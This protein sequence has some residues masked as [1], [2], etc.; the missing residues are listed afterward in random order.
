M[1]IGLVRD[2]PGKTTP[3]PRPLRAVAVAAMLLTTGV[4]VP[5][6]PSAACTLD[7][8]TLKSLTVDVRS[9]K[10]SYTVGEVAE[11]ALSVTRPGRED[12]VGLGVPVDAPTSS[13]AEGMHTGVVVSVGE[14]YVFEFGDPT[15]ADGRATARVEL[16]PPMPLG[17]PARVV[18]LSWRTQVQ[19]PCLVV[20]EHGSVE[21][22]RAFT[23][24]R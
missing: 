9:A 2:L 1:G 24:T 17:R 13:P 11:F 23:V 10:S 19:G 7:A 20:S 14:E 12:V 21:L 8:I 18:A 15:D 3:R 4:Q 6:S 5:A 22:A 16:A